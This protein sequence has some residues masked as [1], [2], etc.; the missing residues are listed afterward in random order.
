MGCDAEVNSL[1]GQLVFQSAHPH[2]VRYEISAGGGRFVRFNPR[3]R[4]GCDVRAALDAAPDD[5]VSI[6][7]PAW[8]AMSLRNRVGINPMF[9][10]AHPHGVR[11]GKSFDLYRRARSFNPRTRMGCDLLLP[12]QNVRI[13]TFQSAHPHGVRFKVSSNRILILSFNPRTRMGCDTI[14]FNYYRCGELVSIRAPAWGAMGEI[15]KMRKKCW[16]FQS[17]HPHGVRSAG[18]Y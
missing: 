10:S 14:Q 17:A 8:G 16:E 7:A 15:L 2:G 3:T 4:M 5:P 12:V 13:I 1:V 9:Q 6:R 11:S 18:G